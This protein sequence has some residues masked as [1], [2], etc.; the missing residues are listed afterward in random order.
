MRRP[1]EIAQ[2]RPDRAAAVEKTH[3]LS[4]CRWVGFLILGCHNFGLE[5]WLKP[6]GATTGASPTVRTSIDPVNILPF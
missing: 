3:A 5:R 1:I 2:Q 6:D 4:A